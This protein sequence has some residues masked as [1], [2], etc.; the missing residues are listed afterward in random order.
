MVK[1]IGDHAGRIDRRVLPWRNNFRK[2]TGTQVSLFYTA[3]LY[4]ADGFHAIHIIPYNEYDAQ[5]VRSAWF[6]YF[7]P[8]IYFSGIALF[9]DGFADHHPYRIQ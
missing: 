6:N 8:C 4:I 2:T 3:D 7:L 9:R 1:R 5:P